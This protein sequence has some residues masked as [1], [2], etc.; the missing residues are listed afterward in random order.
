MK[1]RVV[2]TAMEVVS[3]LGTGVDLFWQNLLAGRSGIAKIAGYDASSY[4]TQIGGEIKD[5]NLDEY[6]H[7]NKPKRYSKATQF[8]MYCAKKAIE[9]SGLS[10]SELIKAGTFIGT[11]LGGTPQS[12]E[13]YK[14]FFN[15]QWRKIPALTITRGMPN[16]VANMIAIDS[17][18]QGKN[19]TISNKTIFRRK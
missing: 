11:G 8:A 15:E 5:F 2:I 17:G 14:Y 4:P 16:S 19:L 13:A 18:L 9:K 7:L 10:Q 1:K 3:S 6:P 12:E